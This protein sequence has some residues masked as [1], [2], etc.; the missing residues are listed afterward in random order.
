MMGASTRGRNS[1]RGWGGFQEKEGAVDI[2]KCSRE[3]AKEPDS[4][5]V[6]VK[7]RKLEIPPELVGVKLDR[8]GQI[9]KSSLSG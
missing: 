7:L 8:W 6:F 5:L 3:G 4:E 9:C 1:F 2:G